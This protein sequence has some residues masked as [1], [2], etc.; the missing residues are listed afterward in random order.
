MRLSLPPFF[1][2]MVTSK[3]LPIKE[4]S[5][6]RSSRIPGVY[7]KMAL[8]TIYIASSSHFRETTVA[9]AQHLTD[10]VRLSDPLP[11]NGK[12]VSTTASKMKPGSRPPVILPW[13][14]FGTYKLGKTQAMSATLQALQQG[15]RGIDTA[16]IYGG[17]T[18]E[19]LVGQALNQAFQKG[20]VHSREEI[21][22]TT[23]HW[24]KYHGYDL[25][26]EC[27]RLSLN[28]LDTSYVDLYLMHWPGPAWTTMC[29][30]KD[31][32][33]KDPWVYASTDAESMAAKRAE[34]WRAMED[35]YR[36]GLV[37]A[38]GVSNMT[39]QHLRKLKESASIWPPACNQV[40]VH[41]LYP[42][43]DLLE[44]CQREGIVVQAYA[45]LG[46]Q[47]TGKSAWNQLLG[48]GNRNK[49]IPK[50][51]ATSDLLHAEPVLLL[52]KIHSVTPAQVLL[53]W[54]LEKQCAMIPKTTK[55]TRLRENAGALRF[56]LSTSEVEQLQQDLARVVEINN[57]RID[58]LESLTRLCWRSD[59]LRLLDFK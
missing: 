30:S 33:E 10:G 19:R 29:R 51:I 34:T 8:P 24:R 2:L 57:P 13:V 42:Q 50:S 36:Q 35:A 1:F 21:F 31:E 32:V 40:E 14:G 27:L 15:Y 47:D 44:Y 52:A 49:A 23:K 4:T 48:D 56:A 3:S 58:S 20:I 43:T 59:P 25:T 12:K 11:L 18:T 54:G 45:S 38:I 16:F 7:H 9:K 53:R 5:R 6:R 26:M 28:R 17:E 41:P 46:G 39:V 22:L 37:R 55:V